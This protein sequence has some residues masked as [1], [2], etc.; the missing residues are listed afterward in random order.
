MLFVTLCKV[1]QTF[2]SGFKWKL[3]GAKFCYGAVFYALK[4]G[5]ESFELLYTVSYEAQAGSSSE[6]V[7]GTPAYV[8]SVSI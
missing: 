2:K 5:Q 8:Y 6:S 1:V 7:N 3:P 4:Q